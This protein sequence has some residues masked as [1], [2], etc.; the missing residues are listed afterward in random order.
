MR[1][2]RGVFYACLVN[3]ETGIPMSARSTGEKER[4]AALIAV[5]GW[6]RDGLPGRDGERRKAEAAFGLDGILR[7]IRKAELD[8]AGALAIVKALKE[9]G[10]IDT[11]AVPAG[12][13]SV[14]FVRLF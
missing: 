2:R 7:S 3:Q 14:N 8:S 9:R 5:S 11:G 6:L 12:K 10:P 4:D 13:G 1:K